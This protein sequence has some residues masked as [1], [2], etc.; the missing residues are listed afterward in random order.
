MQSPVSSNHS[1]S[2]VIKYRMPEENLILTF[3]PSLVSLLLAS[4]KKKGAPLNEQE[5]VEI[6]D[7]ATVVALPEDDAAKITAERGY[8]D[9][10]ADHCW[11]EWQRARIDLIESN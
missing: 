3:V 2:A 5:V 6:R 1:G 9:I 11:E 10:D 8:R 7:K 4:E